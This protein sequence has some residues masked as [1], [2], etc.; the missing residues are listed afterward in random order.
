M[1][2]IEESLSQ[3]NDAAWDAICRSQMV[4]EFN[5]DGT[6]LWANSIFLEAMGYTLQE[7]RGR[8]HLIFCSEDEVTSSQ[9]EKFWERLRRG[10]FDAGEYR[11]YTKDG[12]PIWMQATY[13][14]ILNAQGIAVCI[15]KIATD[16]TSSK[17]LS[18]QLSDT[19]KQME[20][21]VST[22][23]AIASQT[24]LLSLNASIEAARA[25]DAGKGFAVVAAEVKKL[26]IDTRSVTEQAAAMLEATEGRSVEGPF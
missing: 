16:V 11:R 17:L 8:H 13:N 5:L 2:E 10:E 20:A 14:P 7:I 18:F 25:G 22:I 12:N 9:Y 19:L 6:I 21:I 15:L 1:G 24:Q 26:A 4:I 3:H 23:Q